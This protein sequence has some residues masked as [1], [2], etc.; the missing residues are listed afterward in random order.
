MPRFCR[1]SLNMC[2]KILLVAAILGIKKNPYSLEAWILKPC[3]VSSAERNKSTKRDTENRRGVYRFFCTFYLD[4]EAISSLT[5]LLLLL[6]LLLPLLLLLLLRK[7]ALQKCEDPEVSDRNVYYT[8]ARTLPS[9]K[10]IGK[11]VVA[12]LRAYSWNKVVVLYGTAPSTSDNKL[13]EY[14]TVIC[15]QCHFSTHFYIKFFLFLF[16]LME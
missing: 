15:L 9:T 16:R 8:F 11:S 4:N 13:N 2:C 10:K 3:D 6:L 7:V 1:D 14:L 5:S 12:L